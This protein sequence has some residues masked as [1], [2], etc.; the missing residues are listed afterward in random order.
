MENI[1]I[2]L[3][4]QE[5]KYVIGENNKNEEL[6]KKLKNIYCLKILSENIPKKIYEKISKKLK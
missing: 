4:E 6:V 1:L 5:L 3:N 2:N